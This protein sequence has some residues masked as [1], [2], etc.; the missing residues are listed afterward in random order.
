MVDK[1]EALRKDYSVDEILAEARIKH[2]Q[3][4][5]PA[6]KVS[7]PAPLRSSD[8]IARRAREALKAEAGETEDFVRETAEIESPKT[9]IPESTPMAASAEFDGEE[10]SGGKKKRRSLFGRKKRIPE[11]S[12]EE[13]IYYGLQLKPL[14]EY[15]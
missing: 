10:G 13:D 12:E 7:G 3:N 9:E 1:K 14:E 11:P 5:A 15:R 2:D 6:P 8:E 4:N